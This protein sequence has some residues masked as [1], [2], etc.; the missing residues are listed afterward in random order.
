MDIIFE[1]DG[2]AHSGEIPQMIVRGPCQT[3]VDQKHLEPLP[4]PFQEFVN[5]PVTQK[6]FKFYLP[7]SANALNLYFSNVFD[8]WPRDW[9]WVG[10][11]L[12]GKHPEKILKIDGYEILSVTGEPITL[13][14]Q[15]TE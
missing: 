1:A 8:T 12:Y 9:T 7:N 10:V 6:S 2:I 5:S 15:V 13:S 14:P 11:R 3:D 4:T